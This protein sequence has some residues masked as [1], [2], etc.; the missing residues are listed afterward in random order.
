MT[1]SAA[2]RVKDLVMEIPGAARILDGWG[3]DY[4]CGGNELL[5]DACA[6]AG[7]SVDQLVTAVQSNAAPASTERK[8]WRS[9]SLTNLANYIL[10]KHH[11]FTRD[12]MERLT[13]LLSKV[14]S[15][16]GQNH[17]ELI[18]I[19]HVFSSLCNELTTHM[20]KEEQILFP[21]IFQL[22]KAVSQGR[23]APFSPFG[24]VQNPVRMMM[25]E[26]DNAGAMLRE[27]RDLS[28]RY[29]VPSD[30]CASFRLLYE[31]LDGFEQDLRQH[32]HLE[33]NLLF[34]RAIELEGGSD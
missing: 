18:Q 32:I 10:E 6:R 27:L 11:T 22:D 14:C 31:G 12:E 1:T 25:I 20:Y 33:N 8:D 16:H 30:G 9:E 4:C 23:P 26:H 28:E 13:T 5:E 17:P 7:I 29:T 15:V 21:Y 24:T 3:I 19:Q 2:K 34:P